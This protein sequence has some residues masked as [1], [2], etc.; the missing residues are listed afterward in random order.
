MNGAGK[1]GLTV[2]GS[3]LAFYYVVAYERLLAKSFLSYA[4]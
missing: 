4:T 1:S 3:E 2:A